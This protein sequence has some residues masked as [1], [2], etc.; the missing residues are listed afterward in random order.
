MGLELG[1]DDYVTKPFALAQLFARLTAVRRRAR[2]AVP[3]SVRLDPVE[4]DLRAFRAD[5]PDRSE[6]LTPIETEILRYLAARRG[7]A[8]DRVEMLKDLFGVEHKGET[9]TLDNHVARLRRKVEVDPS[10]PR[11]IVTVHGI[12]Y[13]LEK[14]AT[15]S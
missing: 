6:D 2:R 12:G 14:E 4:V 1:A 13:R 8:V 11:W 10:S 7:S 15:G 5:F 9:R 3:E